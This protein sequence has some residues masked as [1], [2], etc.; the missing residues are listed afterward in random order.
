MDNIDIAKLLSEMEERINLKF[1]ETSAEISGV[2]QEISETRRDVMAYIESKVERN[3]QTV[4]EGV[5]TLINREPTPE[6]V[7]AH[8][9]DMNTR[10]PALEHASKNHRTEI[11]EI[12]KELKKAQ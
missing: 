4:A 3:I 2:K 12:R 1:S 6:T 5:S 11:D 7:N 10:V 8:M 9:E